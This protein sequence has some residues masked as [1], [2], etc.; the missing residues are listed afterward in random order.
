MSKK[1]K[2]MKPKFYYNEKGKPVMVRLSVEDFNN[3]YSELKKISADA[4]KRAS[5]KKVLK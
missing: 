3:F 4:K 5:G 1:K 2:V